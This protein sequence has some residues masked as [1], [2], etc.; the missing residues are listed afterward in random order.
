MPHGV[1]PLSCPRSSRNARIRVESTPCT[2]S[3]KFK[4]DSSGLDPGI[5][6]QARGLLFLRMERLRCSPGACRMDPRVKPWDD[7]GEVVLG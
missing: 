1:A 7:G 5:H 2:M 6:N 3:T 4:P